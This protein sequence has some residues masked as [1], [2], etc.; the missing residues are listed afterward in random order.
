MVIMPWDI[1][2][3]SNSSIIPAGMEH[4]GFTV[5]NYAA[6][7]ARADKLFAANPLMAPLP[8]GAGPE[9]QARL[10]RIRSGCALYQHHLTDCDGILLS[11]AEQ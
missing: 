10:E 1:T 9:G 8:I 5:A 6:F 7:K 11:V 3:Y 4:I 2:D